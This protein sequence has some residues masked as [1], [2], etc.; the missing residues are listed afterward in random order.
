M[1]ILKVRGVESYISDGIASTV[2]NILYSLV[3]VIRKV[4]LEERTTKVLKVVDDEAIKRDL[5]EYTLGNV[6]NEILLGIFEGRDSDIYSLVS[7]ATHV[8]M[9]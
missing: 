6:I 8:G 1:L 9:W 5:A 7:K 2:S 4:G 3:V